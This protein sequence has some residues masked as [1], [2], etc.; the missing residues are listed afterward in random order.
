M[1]SPWNETHF[2]AGDSLESPGAEGALSHGSGGRTL[3][4]QR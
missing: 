2:M 3:S 1:W 4:A